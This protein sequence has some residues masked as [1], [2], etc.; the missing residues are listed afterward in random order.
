MRS[1]RFLASVRV[2]A[3]IG[4]ALLLLGVTSCDKGLAPPP[5]SSRSTLLGK[6]SFKGTWPQVDSTWALA[7]ALVPDAP[8]FTPSTLISGVLSGAVKYL[9]LKYHTR[10][11]T[12]LFEI[13]TGTYH[14][15]GIAQQFGPDLFADLK[16]V[17]FAHNRQDSALSFTF[18]PGAEL[19]ADII[20]N[21]DSLP[22]QPFVQ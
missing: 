16:V 13:D 5:A 18:G 20:V 3:F 2:L 19:T 22:R 15:L 14:Y 17:G 1:I 8:P 12:F 7:I 4:C 11:T 21:W 10:D 6:V 9:P